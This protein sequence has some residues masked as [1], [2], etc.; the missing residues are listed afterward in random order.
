MPDWRRDVVHSAC[1]KGIWASRQRKSVE[2]C[3]SDA[4]GLAT[5]LIRYGYPLHFAKSVFRCV[6]RADGRHVLQFKG[7]LMSGFRIQDA[8][9]ELE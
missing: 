7:C 1:D 6:L 3:L 9:V 4:G 5:D 8:L 2:E